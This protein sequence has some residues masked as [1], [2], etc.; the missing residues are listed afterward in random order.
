MQLAVLSSIHLQAF[1]RDCDQNCEQS[2]LFLILTLVRSPLRLSNYTG[3]GKSFQSKEKTAK[4]FA[5]FS[6]ILKLSSFGA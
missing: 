2:I 1:G 3:A 6:K 5:V 4:R